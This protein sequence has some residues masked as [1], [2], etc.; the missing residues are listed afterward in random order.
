MSFSLPRISL[1]RLGVSVG[2]DIV[3]VGL[4]MP[5]SVWHQAYRLAQR[6]DWIAATELG[7]YGQAAGII[8]VAGVLEQLFKPGY[9]QDLA[10]EILSK[11]HGDVAKRL[12]LA[13]RKELP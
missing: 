2:S 5:N 10:R 6:R 12:L 4:D 13:G 1:R 7:R 8:V 3:K 9:G 11:S